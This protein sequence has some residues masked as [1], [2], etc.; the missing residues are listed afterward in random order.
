[1]A[2]VDG[3]GNFIGTFFPSDIAGSRCSNGWIAALAVKMLG[4]TNAIAAAKRFRINKS[5]NKFIW[6]RTN[7]SGRLVLVVKKPTMKMPKM[8]KFSGDMLM[9][10]IQK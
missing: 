5:T 4:L 7:W 3:I 10:R 1:M 6:F 9:K 2:I 8:P